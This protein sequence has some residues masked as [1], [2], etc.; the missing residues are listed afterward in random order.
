MADDKPDAVPAV[1]AEHLGKRYG[2]ATVLDGI[3]LTATA[4]ESIALIGHNGAGKTTLLKLLLGLTRPSCGRVMVLG[5]DPANAEP[6]L[7][8]RIGYLPE[9]VSFQSAASAREI[10]GLYAG[11]KGVPRPQ[12]Q[13]LLE[14]VGLGKATDRPLRTYSKGMRQRLGLAQAMLGSP[15]L[16][17]LDEPTSGLDPV[18]RRD[19]YAL[20]QSSRDAGTTVLIST[21]ALTE[22]EGRTDRIAVLSGG[23]LVAMGSLDELRRETGLPVRIRILT[24]PGKASSVAGSL[25]PSTPLQHVNESCV[26]L[27]CSESEKMRIISRVASC[28]AWVR[29]V[30]IVRPGLDDIYAS[31]VGEERPS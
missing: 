14:R 21:H 9:H 4:G 8:R 28:P 25:L 20:V 17:L 26:S 22:I 5:R 24:V 2:S 30:E 6:G 31:F 10:L 1:Q 3:S 12:V 7:R 11:L 13:R 19:V 18:L 29:D 15:E 23:R 16:L 27:S